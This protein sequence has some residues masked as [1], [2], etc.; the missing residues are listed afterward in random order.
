MMRVWPAAVARVKEEVADMQAIAAK[1][2]PA[3]AI[4]PWDYLYYAEKVR[5]ARYDLDQGELKPYFEL[6]NMVAAAMWSAERRYDIRFTEITGKVPV[7]HPDVR[8]FEVTDTRERRAPRPVLPRQ[9]RARRQAVGRV[10]VQLSRRSSK[11]DG[12]D[13]GDLVE[14]QQLRQ[15][16]AGRAGADLARRRDDA[17]PRVRP[18]AAQPAAGHHV[19]GAV[20][21]AARLRRVSVAGE[22]ALGADARGARQV[23]P[24]LQDGRADAAG[25]G[26]QDQAV[27][28]VQPG[29]RDGRVPRRGDPRHGRCTRGRTARSIRPRSSASSSRA[30]ACRG[31]SRCG[32]G[33]RTSITCSAATRTRP[34]TTATCGRT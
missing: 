5:K 33:C 12:G 23:R 10:G 17:V 13:H 4:E 28:E 15:G 1:E 16:R 14:Q 30:S 25:A 3:I 31:R 6:N 21:D 7:F 19:S 22:R 11:L 20:D 29:L 8:V 27:G 32:T 34:A 2:G 26:R 9:L 18:R 24:S